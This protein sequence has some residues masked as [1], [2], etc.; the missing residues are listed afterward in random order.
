MTIIID[1]KAQKG[2]VGKNLMKTRPLDDQKIPDQSDG[3]IFRST[4]TH[5]DKQAWEAGHR[6]KW[7]DLFSQI[8]PCTMI[9]FY[10][11][12]WKYTI[13]LLILICNFEVLYSFQVCE[14]GYQISHMCKR[15]RTFIISWI[16]WPLTA[17]FGLNYYCFGLIS[18]IKTGLWQWSLICK[19]A[20]T[21]S[22]QRTVSGRIILHF[23]ANGASTTLRIYLRHDF[24]FFF[25]L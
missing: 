14:H 6:C 20:A 21:P 9:P 1:P 15:R 24:F 23:C 4:L 19:Q 2:V 7:L 17:E 13:V 25:V 11:V 12:F 10:S 8:V 3:L 22:Q 5:P 18:F 16:I